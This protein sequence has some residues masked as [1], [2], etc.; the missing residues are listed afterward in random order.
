MHNEDLYP[1][2]RFMV[3]RKCKNIFAAGFGGKNECPDCA[4]RQ[5]SEYMPDA[6]QEPP[7]QDSAAPGE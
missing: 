5:V 1:T 3:C 4:S 7:P 6:K 2:R